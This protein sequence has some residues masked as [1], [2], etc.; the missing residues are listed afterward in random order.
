[1][2]DFQ[3]FDDGVTTSVQLGDARW[4]GGLQA[5]AYFLPALML[6][7]DTLDEVP[8]G[9]GAYE[10]APAVLF[11]EAPYEGCEVEDGVEGVGDCV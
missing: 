10:Y 7:P 3:L 2:S 9:R 1:M 8:C 4:I 6:E 5:A 11:E